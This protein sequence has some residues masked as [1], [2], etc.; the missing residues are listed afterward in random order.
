ML[1]YGRRT[2]DGKVV[3]ILGLERGN[4]E[5]LLAGE[6][7]RV[8]RETHGTAV[9]EDLIVGV[10]FGE[11]QEHIEGLLRREGV[12]TERTRQEEPPGRSGR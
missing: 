4:V 10:V 7:I 12:I 11:T 8:R 2:P 1:T 3:L 6:W 5:R 9:P